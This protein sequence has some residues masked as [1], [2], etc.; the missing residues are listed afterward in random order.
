LT[1]VVVSSV[2]PGAIEQVTLRFA[3]AAVEYCTQDV[4][5]AVSCSSVA[6]D[7]GMP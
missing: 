5:A 6:L 3:D 2:I 1:D 4:T 7:A